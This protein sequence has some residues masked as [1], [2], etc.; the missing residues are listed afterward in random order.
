MYC[1]VCS[2]KEI[3]LLCRKNGQS[4][5]ICRTCG[6]A[7]VKE[8]KR[9]QEKCQKS[10]F[11]K[12]KKQSDSKLAWDYSRLK[13]EQV[14]FPRLD[15]IAKFVSQ[16]GMLDIGCANGAFL[17]AAGEKGWKT[18]GV[19]LRKKSIDIARENGIDVLTKP[20][21]ELDLPSKHYSAITMWQV[22]EHL[23]DPI[24]VLQECCR[25]LKPGGLL[26]ISTPNLKSIGW[27]LLKENWPA[28]DPPVHPHLFNTSCLSLLLNKCGFTEC[29]LETSDIL[30]AS[31]KLLKRKLTGKKIMKPSNTM[32]SFVSSSSETN[33]KRLFLYRKLL[34]FFLRPT[35]FGEDIYAYFCKT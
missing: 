1:L 14:F 2:G 33:L 12:R 7:F 23:P 16:N 3:G 5:H 24:V 8:W 29:R 18:Q 15:Q 32:A 13:K 28:I 25:I 9:N 35:G 20:V 6:H 34:N 19:E 11:E 31:V 22:V 30:P 10:P 4:Y 21:E 26:A 17:M 27:L